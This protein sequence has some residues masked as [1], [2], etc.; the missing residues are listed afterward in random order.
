MDLIQTT[1][2]TP[3]HT[4]R[5]RI[6]TPAGPTALGRCVGDALLPAAY[7]HGCGAERAHDVHAGDPDGKTYHKAGHDLAI[8]K[9]RKAEAIAAGYL[10]ELGDHRGIRRER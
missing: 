6:D 3:P 9:A 4:H 8:R 2:A 7:P 5:W 1:D 10:H